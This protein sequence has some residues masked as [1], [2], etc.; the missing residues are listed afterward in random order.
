MPIEVYLVWK[1]RGTSINCFGGGILTHTI[2]LLE[3]VL[4]RSSII[5]LYPPHNHRVDLIQLS[6]EGRLLGLCRPFFFCH[7][8]SCDSS[9]LVACGPYRLQKS[10]GSFS[11]KLIGTCRS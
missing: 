11:P 10:V 3:V 2:T 7:G 4:D 9:S 8:I 1:R 5:I 6:F